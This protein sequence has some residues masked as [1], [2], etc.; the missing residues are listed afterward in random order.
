MTV[1]AT[2]LRNTRESAKRIRFESVSSVTATNVQD[3]ILQVTTLSPIIIPTAVTFVM[4][5]YTPLTTDQILEV[6]T[7]G[8]AVTIQ[9]PLSVTR[10]LDLEVKDITGN[11]AANPISVQRAGGE[12]IDGLTTYPLDS[13]YA[14]AKF[15]P[16]TGG[17]YVHS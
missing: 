9:M 15:G 12:N 4:S 11:A 7:S 3:A 17:Y 1:I 5:P 6:D 14:A 8:G 16:K 2:D 13:A 10:T